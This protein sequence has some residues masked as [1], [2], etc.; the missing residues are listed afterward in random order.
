VNDLARGERC[1]HGRGRDRGR[2]G[3]AVG[4]LKVPAMGRGT[5]MGKRRGRGDGMGAEDRELWAET[6]RK[7]AVNRVGVE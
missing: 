3:A 6:V 1:G 7:D 2:C 4:V 5:C